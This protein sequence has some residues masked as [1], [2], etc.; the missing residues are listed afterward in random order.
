[1]YPFA[2]HK[3]Y[4]HKNII[5]NHSISSHANCIAPS[6]YFIGTQEKDID[7]GPSEIGRPVL[8]LSFS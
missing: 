2:H 5:L 3:N 6:L 1:M 8:L 4:M 7:G